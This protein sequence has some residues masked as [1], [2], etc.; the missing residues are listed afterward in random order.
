MEYH[1]FESSNV[2]CTGLAFVPKEEGGI[3]ME[4]E[5]DDGW[6]I[7]FVHNDDINLSQNTSIPQ[8]PDGYVF[9]QSTSNAFLSLATTQD[10][11]REYR[12]EI[13]LEIIVDP[14]NSALAQALKFLDKSPQTTV[15]RNH[16]RNKRKE[17][18]AKDQ[19][20]VGPDIGS[21]HSTFF[22]R[23]VKFNCI[24]SA[25]CNDDGSSRTL[26]VQR[27]GRNA[28]Q[29]RWRTRGEKATSG[30]SAAREVEWLKGRD[31]GEVDARCWLSSLHEWRMKRW[32]QMQ[33]D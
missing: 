13:M 31:D 21:F 23:A 1:A 7:A 20:K 28:S 2:F 16:P 33:G 11:L 25:V 8:T 12:K 17:V 6:I 10:T 27:Q 4:E 24:I 9:K 22:C 18:E 19:W 14:N 3:E 30:S 26:M 29:L 32:Q 5:K 15:H